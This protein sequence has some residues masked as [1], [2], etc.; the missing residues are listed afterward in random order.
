LECKTAIVHSE[1]NPE[2]NTEIISAFD[3]TVAVRQ[4]GLMHAVGDVSAAVSSGLA[5][6]RRHRKNGTAH[7]GHLQQRRTDYQQGVL[8]AGLPQAERSKYGST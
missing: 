3:L 4:L 7:S 6:T 5:C 2:R 8:N 1:A